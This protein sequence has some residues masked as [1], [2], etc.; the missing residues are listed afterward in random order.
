[1]KFREIPNV[2]PKNNKPV[3]Y[4]ACSACGAAVINRNIHIQ[5]HKHINNHRTFPFWEGIDDN[6]DF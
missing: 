1:M 4:Y 6:N 3:V 5:W 2:N